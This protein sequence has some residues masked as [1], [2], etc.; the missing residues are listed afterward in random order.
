MSLP[1]IYAPSKVGQLYE[2]DLLRS[3]QTGLADFQHP[4]SEDRTRVL[5][6][7]IDVQVD[8]VFPAPVGRLPV[9]N[10][11]ADT[12]RTIE[13]LYHN[14]Q[15]VTH[16]AASLDTHVPLQIFY[17]SWWQNAN[18]E[19][20]APYTVITREDVRQGKWAPVFEPDWSLHYLE[21][22]E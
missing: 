9:P 12:Q 14:I 13:W 20:P 6:W 18:R 7:L 2:P 4:A 5:L 3:Y 21:E 1:S 19:S 15:S 16:I 11:V 8:F 17:P 10:A 22:L